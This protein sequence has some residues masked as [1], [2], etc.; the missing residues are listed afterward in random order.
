MNRRRYASRPTFGYGQQQQ[1]PQFGFGMRSMMKIRLLIGLVIAGFAIFSFLGSKTYNPVTGEKQFVGGI[2]EEQEIALGLQAMPSMV[3]QH[4]GHYPDQRLQDIVDQV[5]QRILQQ[6]AAQETDW[7]FEFHLLSDSQTVNA[8]A[9]PGGQIFLTAALYE[10]LS[11]EGQLAGVLGHEI[12]HV[13]ARHS[14]QRIAKSKLTQG[15]L[16]AVI[17]A[18]GSSSA[19]HMT[20]MIAQMV[21]MKYG[22]GDELESDQLGVKFM[23]DAGYDPRAMIKVMKVLEE[24]SGGKG[25]P[26]FA[27]THPSP[28]N[29]VGKIEDAIR[30]IFPDGVPGNLED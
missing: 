14:A 3:Q 4:G 9:L 22:R 20:Q 29:R 28:K 10:R 11:T 6:S 1:R 18:S 30:A 16:G 24:A 8:F 19:A 15:L 13:V 2:T 26:E 17:A 7:N 23:A 25:P 5:G 21:N 27:S 12:G